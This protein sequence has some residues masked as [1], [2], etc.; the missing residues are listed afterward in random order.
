MV[1][2]PAKDSRKK[3]A[4]MCHIQTGPLFQGGLQIIGEYRLADS[5]FNTSPS[6][7][8]L[9]S[10]G[11]VD[12]TGQDHPSLDGSGDGYFMPVELEVYRVE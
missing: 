7:C 11:Y 1:R 4:L 5:P 10:Y 8:A 3:L 2:L 12:P 9:Y 6:S